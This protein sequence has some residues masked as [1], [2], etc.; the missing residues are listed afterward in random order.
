MTGVETLILKGTRLTEKI[1]SACKAVELRSKKPRTLTLAFD[2]Y[3]V[4]LEYSSVVGDTD[5]TPYYSL[6]SLLTYDE[7]LF[8]TGN[9]QLSVHV[10][11]FAEPDSVTVG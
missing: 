7:L 6:E 11:F 10:D 9:Y 5:T 3:I 2:A 8:E 1:W 4:L